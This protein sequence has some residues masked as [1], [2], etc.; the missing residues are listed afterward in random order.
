M[1]VFCL[2]LQAPLSWGMPTTTDTESLREFCS[3]LGTLRL[4]EIR[5]CLGEGP[6]RREEAEEVGLL[7]GLDEMNAADVAL[8]VTFDGKQA[9]LTILVMELRARL[10]LLDAEGAH[11]RAKIAS[12]G[13]TV[14]EFQS[15]EAP[16][17]KLIA[18]PSTYYPGRYQLTRFDEQGPIGHTDCETL[19]DAIRAAVDTVGDATY[20]VTDT[21]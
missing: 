21:K 9:S 14:V 3:R 7:A 4:P 20:E 16:G 19:D 1:G 18:H 2:A 8:D 6:F 11:E 13:A 12:A 15:P 5:E 17:R 10:R